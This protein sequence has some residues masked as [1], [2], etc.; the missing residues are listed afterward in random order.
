MSNSTPKNSSKFPDRVFEWFLLSSKR[1][2]TGLLCPLPSWVWYEIMVKLLVKR[3][4]AYQS[5]T[6]VIEA[7]QT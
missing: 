1:N 2:S 6:D 4:N 3:N 7:K 5:D